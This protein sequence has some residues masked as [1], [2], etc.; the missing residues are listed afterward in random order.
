MP[1]FYLLIAGVLEVVWATF[2]KL[3][4][5]FS[6]L[7]YSIITVITMIASFFFLSKAIKILSLSISYAI[8]TGIGAIGAII[9]G[10]LFFKESMSILQAFFVILLLIGI[11]GLK[12]TSPH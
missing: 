2:L 7:S 1:W 11:I 3:S 8:W 5:G 12:F 9:V 6:N 10:I 4:N